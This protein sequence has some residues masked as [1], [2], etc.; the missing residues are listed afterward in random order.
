MNFSV[1]SVSRPAVW[2]TQPS[3]QWAPGNLYPGVKRG[4]GVTLTTHP[5][6]CR[7]RECVGPILPLPP[8]AF[9]VCGG[10]ALAFFNV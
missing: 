4:R 10:T 5:V 8:S 2:P 1:A 3:V 9:M 7:G 6:Q